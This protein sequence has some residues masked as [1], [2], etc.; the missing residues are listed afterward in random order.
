MNFYN[1]LLLFS[2]QNSKS[3]SPHVISFLISLHL[4]MKQLK[5]P[6]STKSFVDTVMKVQ[7]CWNSKSIKGT[8][9]TLKTQQCSWNNFTETEVQYSS[10]SRFCRKNRISLFILLRKLIFWGWTE[11]KY[12]WYDFLTHE[13]PA[14]YVVYYLLLYGDACM[15]KGLCAHFSTGR[16]GA[17][18]QFS[19]LKTAPK[20]LYF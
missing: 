4:Q 18:F 8:A 2:L 9:K 5:F 11:R 3:K 12:L 20:L 1:W 10:G 14:S 15:K 16:G 6:R 17:W 19:T 7:H 13:Y